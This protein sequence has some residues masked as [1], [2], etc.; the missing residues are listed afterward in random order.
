MAI[1]KTSRVNSL[2]SR[3]QGDLKDLL[4]NPYP[5][6]DV[7]HNDADL[8][9]M[10][11]ILSPLGGPFVGLR[12][13]FKVTLPLTWPV[14]PPKIKSSSQLDH[15]NVFGSYICSDL[16]RKFSSINGFLYTRILLTKPQDCM[17]TSQRIIMEGI[18]RRLPLEGYSCNC[19]LFSRPRK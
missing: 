18:R 14:D 1:Y 7:H 17:V 9:K 2:L 10:C 8:R 5:G 13:H 19:Y 3:L 6:I 16:L 4:S 11:L 15:P 12:L